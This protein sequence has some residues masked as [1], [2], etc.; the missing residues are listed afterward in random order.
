MPK[1]KFHE[2]FGKPLSLDYKSYQIIS[3]DFGKT[4][5]N[6]NKKKEIIQEI[7]KGFY[8]QIRNQGCVRFISKKENNTIFMRKFH[9]K[10]NKVDEEKKNKKNLNRIFNYK[11]LPK[12]K[13]K[14]I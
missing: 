13:E 14:K 6:K 11:S 4:V 9:K 5:N 10:Y 8:Q 2:K 12:I 7:V 3:N 1:I